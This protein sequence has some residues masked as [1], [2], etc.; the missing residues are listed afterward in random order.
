MSYIITD[1]SEVFVDFRLDGSPEWSV[2]PDLKHVARHK[3]R[4]YKC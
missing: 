3:R 1:K 4:S 2:R